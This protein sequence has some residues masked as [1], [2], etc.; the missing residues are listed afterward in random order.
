[1]VTQ[2]SFPPPCFF[3]EHRYTFG[4]AARDHSNG[5]SAV[6]QLFAFGPKK[7]VSQTES[8]QG[9]FSETFYG[10]V[11]KRAEKK[12]AS[13]GG[14]QENAGGK[15]GNRKRGKKNGAGKARKGGTL[16]WFR[17]RG[18][19]SSNQTSGGVLASSD[20]SASASASSS[21]ASVSSDTRRRQQ[22]KARQALGMTINIVATRPAQDLFPPASFTSSFSAS[23]GSG[24]VS[25]SRRFRGFGGRGPGRG[26][27]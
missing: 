12:K 7:G 5:G 25:N 21:V 3:R 8:G 2:L 16:R 11:L 14:N 19:R 24:S 27:W 20:S 17:G 4:K 22:R 18:G 15:A 10:I 26:R 9:T 23:Y 6:E 1:M 13:G